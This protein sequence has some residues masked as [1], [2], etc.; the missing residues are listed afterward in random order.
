MLASIDKLSSLNSLTYFQPHVG[1]TVFFALKFIYFERW[2]EREGGMERKRNTEDP[3]HCR[4]ELGVGL[5]P[6]NLEILT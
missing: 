1:F 6:M 5:E 2:R 4:E 3:K